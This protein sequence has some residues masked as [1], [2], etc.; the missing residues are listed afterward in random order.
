M[1]S[2]RVAEEAKE[3]DGYSRQVGK[4]ITFVCWQ[5]CDTAGYLR[6]FA[7]KSS[8]AEIFLKL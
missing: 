7:P 8:H 4:S 5:L 6:T 2:E 1:Y 3:E